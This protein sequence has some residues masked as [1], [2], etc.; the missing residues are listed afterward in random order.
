[1][2]LENIG[3]SLEG[4]L[5]SGIGSP[6]SLFIILALSWLSVNNHECHESSLK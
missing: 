6:S 2:M 4:R 5:H 1:M 3:L